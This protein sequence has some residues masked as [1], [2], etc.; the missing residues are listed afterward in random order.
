MSTSVSHEP[1]A[2]KIQVTAHALIVYLV[3]ERKLEVPL[4]WFPRLCKATSAQR[5]QCRLIGRGIGIH[6]PKIDED[7][8]VGALLKFSVYP[9]SFQ[10]DKKQGKSAA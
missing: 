8:S 5:K 7:L 9:L 3:D 4:A 10:K 6:W 2:E 1:R